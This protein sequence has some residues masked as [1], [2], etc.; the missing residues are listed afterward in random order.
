MKWRKLF[1]SVMLAGSIGS[2]LGTNLVALAN[3][4]PPDEVSTTSTEAGTLESI[5]RDPQELL[6]SQQLEQTEHSEETSSSAQSKPD[7][8]NDKN[9]VMLL[10]RAGLSIKIPLAKSN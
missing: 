3:E 7:Q 4:T 8:Q 9:P 6:S 1:Y 2:L 10:L 5:S